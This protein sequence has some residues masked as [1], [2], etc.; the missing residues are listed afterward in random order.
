MKELLPESLYACVDLLKPYFV[1][2][3]GS[4]TR[5]DYGT[6]HEAAFGILLMCL[7]LI[8]FFHPEPAEERSIVL[9][10]FLRYIRLCWKLQDTYRL[11]PAGSHGVWGLDDSSFLGYVFGSAQLLSAFCANFCFHGST[12]CN[13][14]QKGIPVNAVLRPNLPPTNL[15]FLSISRIHEVKTGPFH[16]HSSQLHSIA[17]GVPNWGKVHSGLLKMYEVRSSNFSRNESANPRIG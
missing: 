13:A 11:E 15:Y 5:M 7:T 17:V 14:D 16:E 3:F 4:F 2:S 12:H 8:R 6:G 9:I 10:V 1:I